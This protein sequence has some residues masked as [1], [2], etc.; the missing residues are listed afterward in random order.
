MFFQGDIMRFALQMTPVFQTLKLSE[1]VFLE[2]EQD[3][4]FGLDFINRWVTGQPL[5]CFGL[6][7][8][9]SAQGMQNIQ[10]IQAP[11]T[12]NQETLIICSQ[13]LH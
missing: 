2:Q 4:D 12:K 10:I 7:F 11:K 5:P 8:E 6:I 3:L 1:Q 13:P 9:N